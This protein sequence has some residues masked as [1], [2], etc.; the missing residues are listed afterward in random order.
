MKL[1][2]SLILIILSINLFALRD[3]EQVWIFDDPDTTSF[4]VNSAEP[5]QYHYHA[6]VNGTPHVQNL[7]AEE[8][9]YGWQKGSLEVPG[10]VGFS[11]LFPQPLVSPVYSAMQPQIYAT[12]QLET[13]PLNDHL[14]N[15]TMLDIMDYRMVYTAEKLYFAIKTANP[16]YATSSGFTYFAYM[17]VIVDPISDPEDNP[18]V[19]GLM[20]T[21][22]MAPV[23][24]PGLYKI[25]GSGFN[26]LNRLG[27]IEHSIEDGYLILSCNIADLTADPDFSSWY[28]PDYPLF[29][30]TATTSRITLVNGIQQAD[31][32]DG[33]KVLLKPHYV[34]AVNDGS[35]VLSNPGIMLDGANVVANVDYY[36]ADANVPN[37]ASV[38]V[39]GIY[40]NQL[41]P[42]SAG[43]LDFNS[44]VTY[45]SVPL[46]LPEDWQ[47][48]VFTFSDGVA[49]VQLTYDNPASFIANATAI[50]MPELRIYPNPTSGTLYLK[51]DMAIH[52]PVFIYNLKG[53][54]MGEIDLSSKEAESDISKL[55]SGIYL[56]KAK[57]L[58][59]RKF[60]KM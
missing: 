52:N 26:G 33:V 8:W 14:Y 25:T 41:Y 42:Q 22:S 54:R 47:N 39:D 56:L 37:Y 44:T 35:P 6:M 15:N 19:Y 58:N 10:Y 5:V 3:F 36:D 28:D 40:A 13:D 53:Q 11:K 27:D 16:S 1:S 60:L 4:I 38:L 24:S 34:E 21:V 30:T 51:S 20:Y 45:A 32:T 57:G 9:L 31:M 50:P 29:T 17:P 2:L 55:S 59:S 18:I 46:D 48:L 43:D 7:E 23:I 49:N 12:T